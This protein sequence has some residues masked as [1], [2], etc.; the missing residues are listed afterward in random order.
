MIETI[1]KER[2]SRYGPFKDNAELAQGLKELIYHWVK[3]KEVRQVLPDNQREALDLIATKISRIV[4]GDSS[5]ADNWDDI[6]GY[7][8]LIANSLRKEQ[9]EVTFEKAG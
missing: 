8:T 2:G 5:Y 7:A 4:T 6:A 1:L 9:N 3:A